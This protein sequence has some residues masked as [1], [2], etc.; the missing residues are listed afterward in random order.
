M[1]IRFGNRTM[2]HVHILRRVPEPRNTSMQSP[3]RV[4]L[5]E[6]TGA[7]QTDV[8]TPF[9][10]SSTY[11]M[12]SPFLSDAIVLDTSSDVAQVSDMGHGRT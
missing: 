9:G 12:L 10:G 8:Y 4:Y 3:R 6:R 5:Y 2:E 11:V 7:S 1:N